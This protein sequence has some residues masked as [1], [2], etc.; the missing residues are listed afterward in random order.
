MIAIGKRLSDGVRRDK[1]SIVVDWKDDRLR[2]KFDAA[3]ALKRRAESAAA[4]HVYRTLGNS[5]RIIFDV[6]SDPPSS[7]TRISTGTV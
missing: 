2:S 7:I 1:E 5:S 4:K 3:V 6:A